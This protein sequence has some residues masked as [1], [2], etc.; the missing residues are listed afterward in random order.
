M[1][2]LR[3]RPLLLAAALLPA[4]VL[5]AV[6]AAEVSAAVVTAP[7]QRGELLHTLRAFATVQVPTSATQTVTFPRPL[8]VLAV[9][10]HPGQAVRRGQ[11]LAL[12][13]ADAASSLAWAQAQNA[14]RFAR[15]ELDRQLA[16]QAQQLA[17]Q[18]QVD[19]ARKALADAQ[20]Q[21]QALQQQG[22][23]QAQ[24]A[25]TAPFDGVVLAVSAA[26]GDVLAA[27]SPLL[28]LGR[29]GSVQAAASVP[30]EDAARLQPGQAVRLTAV[31]DPQRQWLGTLRSVGAAVDAKTQR[32]PLLIAL[33]AQPAPPP[34]GTALQADIVLGRWRGWVVP[35]DAV[36]QDAHGAY[37]Y[38]DDHGKARRVPVHIALDAGLQTGITGPVDPAL[39]LV[40]QGNDVLRPGMGLRVQGGGR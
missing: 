26:P 24:T 4:A 14:V 39:P 1:T 27:G 25:V 38:Q 30:P 32:L 18:S 19:A 6:R 23:G 15:D 9:D 21:L 35:R 28:Q 5:P 7:L 3:L 34:A 31:F 33:P 8:R 17:T 40:V 37:V 36:L 20:A 13:A 29:A 12:L 10:V 16:L 11:T 2:L 22:A